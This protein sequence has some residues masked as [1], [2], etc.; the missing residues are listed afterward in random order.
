[1][2]IRHADSLDPEDA[3]TLA[4]PVR[5]AA[6]PFADV[7]L[8]EGDVVE[9]VRLNTQV[10]TVLGLA[11]NP[12]TFPY[13]TDV[14]YN[15]AQAVAFA[16]GGDDV[17][18]PRYVSVYRQDATGA[19]VSARFKREGNSLAK[20]ATLPIHP[21]DIIFIEQTFR[22]RTRQFFN[23]FFRTG[24]FVGATYDIADD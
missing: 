24:V 19:L 10:F 14:R 9:V 1:V 13:P 17:A 11:R 8:K 12:G 6:I 20:A 21:G 7:A 2:R 23:S 3:K 15:L 16:G 18:D 5:E 22:T 4:L